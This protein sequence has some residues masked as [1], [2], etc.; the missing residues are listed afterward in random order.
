MSDFVNSSVSISLWNQT[1]EFLSRIIKKSQGARLL[2]VR[3]GYDRV[4]SMEADREMIVR[5]MIV[6]GMQKIVEF[7]SKPDSPV[8]YSPDLKMR[9]NVR[10]FLHQ[11]PS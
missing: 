11:M 2:R 4:P 6:R 7:V 1:R 9:F 8:L 10:I 5:G 3:E